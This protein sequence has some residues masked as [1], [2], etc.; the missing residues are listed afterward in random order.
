MSVTISVSLQCR[1]PETSRFLSANSND[2]HHRVAAVES[3]DEWGSVRIELEPDLDEQPPELE[4]AWAQAHVV[5]ASHGYPSTT[6]TVQ[7]GM[8]EE[9]PEIDAVLARMQ[10]KLPARDAGGGGMTH[11]LRGTINLLQRTQITLNDDLGVEE[12]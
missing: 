2:V 12:I 5:L 7:P 3:D 1:F 10:E 6:R 11:W 8:H 4:A 9:R